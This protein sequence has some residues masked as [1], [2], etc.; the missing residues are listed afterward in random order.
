MAIES[1]AVSEEYLEL[2]HGKARYLVSGTGKPVIL[3]H[4]VDY[5]SGGDRWLRTINALSQRLRVLAPDFPGW[6]YGDRLDRE[7]S[8]SFL[9]DFVREF[10]DALGIEHSHIVGHSMG[11]WVASLFAYESPQRVDKLVLVAS[12][13]AST[14]TLPQM[15][16]FTPPSREDLERFVRTTHRADDVETTRLVDEAL[17]KTEIPGAL[18][19][20]RKILAH[21]NDPVNRRHYNILRRLPFI[22]TPTLIVWGR[23]DSVNDVEMGEEIHRRIAG[24]R[25][26]VLENCGHFVP[27]ECPEQFNRLLLEFL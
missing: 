10:Q 6:G 20:Y 5:T 2:S 16:E 1:P 23:D 25:L 26:V 24:S 13:G 17:R 27:T 18:Q 15:T 3:L 22:T 11:G 4:G 12:G 21:M 9:V 14:R 7:Y 8:F 19:S